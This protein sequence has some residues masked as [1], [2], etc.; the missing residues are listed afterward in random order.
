MTNLILRLLRKVAGWFRRGPRLPF[1]E[2]W[3]ACFVT[4]WHSGRSSPWLAKTNDTIHGHG[5][6]MAVLAQVLF[7]DWSADL[8]LACINHDMGEWGAADV[9]YEAKRD[10]AMRSADDR[11]EGDCLD[12]LGLCYA[13]SEIDARRLKFIDRLDAYLWCQLHAPQIQSGLGWPDDL[14][15]L[16]GEADCLGVDLG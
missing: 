5:G 16:L 12:R 15:W 4:R 9:P 1:P 3:L 6:R 8:I 2:A 7:D 10:P 11:L 13:V 14:A